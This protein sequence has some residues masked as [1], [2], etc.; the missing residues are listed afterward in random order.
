MKYSL[1][2][3]RIAG[4]QVFVHW[5]FLI[6]IGYIVYA[7]LKQGMDTI[8]ILWSIFFILTLFACVTLHELGHALAARRYHIKT[9]NITLLPIGG[10]A[11]LESMPEKP[12]EELVVA[13]AG[14]LVNVVI[15]GLL[16]PVL[17]LSGGLDDLDV[18]RFS[19]H[20]F[21]PSLMV[22]NIWL[23][24]FNMIPAFPMDGGR[25]L[26][27]LLSFKFERHVATRIAASIG[28][29]LAIGFVFIGFFSNPFLI[30]IG[31]FIFLGAQGEAQYAQ[32]RSLLSGYTVANAVMK[33]IPALKTT[34]TVDSASDQLLASQNKNFLVV[35]HDNVLGTLSRDEIIRALREGKGAES[36]E[37]FMD[38]DFLSLQLNQPLEEA[39]TTMRTKQKS[40]APVFSGSTLVGMLDTENVA[41][42]LMISEATKKD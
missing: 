23:A 29:L 26:R 12:K 19:H 10:V 7:N 41:E 35:D 21:L 2:L 28:Q 27:A 38:R 39:W 40:A 18:T 5:T 20:N 1:S 9:A 25:V 11:Q 24:V 4:I 13:L 33:Q 30:F 14:P 3:G 37:G 31:V 8:D 42:F 16:F 22:V 32:A 6:L 36:I 15:A 34:D 17:S